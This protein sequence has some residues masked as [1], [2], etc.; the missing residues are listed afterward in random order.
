MGEATYP[1]LG[2]L[3]EPLLTHHLSFVEIRRGRSRRPHSGPSRGIRRDADRSHD[4]G[5]IIGQAGQYITAIFGL[6][7]AWGCHGQR[8]S[9]TLL[10]MYCSRIWD[11]SDGPLE[12]W[13]RM[14]MATV[15]TGLLIV[16]YQ[17]WPVVVST[18]VHRD[19]S[20]IR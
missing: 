18:A 10:V 13:H 7:L 2:V 11:T 12:T 1:G 3:H 19:S 14:S 20:R 17:A 5:F 4:P 9:E 8:W 16:F 15:Y 6:V